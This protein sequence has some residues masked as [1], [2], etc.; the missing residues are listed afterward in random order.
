M[1]KTT[2]SNSEEIADYMLEFAVNYIDEELIREYFFNCKAIL[3][4]VSVDDLQEGEKTQ[5][6]RS[7]YR[8]RIYKK[9]PIE[10]IPPLIVEKGVVLDGNHRLRVAKKCGIKEI[11]I[12]DIVED[13]TI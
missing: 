10:T 8:E 1:F 5:N 3:K 12:Y 6:I 4:I 2:L 7:T 9:L 11:S 13:E